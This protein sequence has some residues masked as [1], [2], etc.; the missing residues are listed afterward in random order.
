MATLIYTQAA[1]LIS[2]ASVCNW[3]SYRYAFFVAL[4]TEASVWIKYGL[5]KLKRV[6][7]T[8]SASKWSSGS[9]FDPEY[10]HLQQKYKSLQKISHYDDTLSLES[11]GTINSR[12]I[13]H[14]KICLEEQ[15][16]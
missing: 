12:G 7:T 4:H 15:T 11:G 14:I 10:G 13:Q 8:V 2:F 9:E 16:V 5:F 1:D 6:I 3:L